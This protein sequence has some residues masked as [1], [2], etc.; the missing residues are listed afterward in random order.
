MNA[1]N[2]QTRTTSP[3]ASVAIRE[4]KA[5]TT[6]KARKTSLENKHLRNGDYFDNCFSLHPL[7]LTEH[8]VNGLVEALLK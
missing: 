2:I 3:R 6:A 7:F 1:A 4:L 5:E 8:A